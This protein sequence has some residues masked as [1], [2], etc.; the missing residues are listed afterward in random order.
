MPPGSVDSL[1][2]VP[3]VRTA[4]AAEWNRLDPRPAFPTRQ[5][6]PQLLQ[7]PVQ[8]GSLEPG[9]FGH[10]GHRAVLAR[11]MEFEVALLEC[12]ARLA[13]RA[14]EVEALFGLGAEIERGGGGEA[15]AAGHDGVDR[16]GVGA[17]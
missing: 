8:V 2:L 5:I 4:A 16:H 12:V 3:T 14:V 9:L 11:E 17:V 10:A 1:V 6:H 13:Q 15:D 7:L